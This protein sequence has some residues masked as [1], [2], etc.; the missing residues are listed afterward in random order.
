M[1]NR[2][3][4]REKQSSALPMVAEPDE[5]QNEQQQQQSANRSS[6]SAVLAGCLIRF[7]HSGLVE[8]NCNTLVKLKYRNGQHFS[9][10]FKVS[11]IARWK[12]R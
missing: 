7:S 11:S 8:L 10:I 4:K 3:C 9:G 12:G 6:D 2:S 1:T 5:D